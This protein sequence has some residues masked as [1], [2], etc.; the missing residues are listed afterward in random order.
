MTSQ[1]WKGAE[2]LLVADG[3]DPAE[4][5]AAVAAERRARTTVIRRDAEATPYLETSTTGRPRFVARRLAEH[6]ERQTPFATGGAQLYVYWDGAYRPGGEKDA[7]ARVAEALKDDWTP[8]AAESVVTYLSDTSP[9]LWEAPPLDIVN[10]ENGLLRLR[11]R[12]LDPHSPDFLSP[13]QIAATYDPDATCPAIDRF[14]ADVLPDGTLPLVLELIGLLAVPDQRH[15]KA[16]MLLG[17]GGSGKS[18]LLGLVRAFVGAENVSAVA[19]HQLEDDRFA[20]ADLYGRLANVFADLDSRALKSSSIFKS[21]TGGDAIRGERKHRSAFTFRPYARLVFSANEAPPT[22]DSSSAFFARWI[23]I[24]LEQR[25]R[26]SKR[27]DVDLLA[28]ITT[29]AELSGLLNRALD[30]L[31]R[32]RRDGFTR[33]EATEKAAER[34]AVDADSVAGFLNEECELALDG[35][36][37]KPA[38]YKA[39]ESWCERSGRRP[40][41]AVRFTHRLRELHGSSVDEVASQG[42]DY[43]LGVTFRE[44]RS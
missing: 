40:L 10:V 36:T 13:V 35:R 39:Y 30:G 6:L 33:A 43:W 4:A 28:K 26:G 42:R 15:Q 29:P 37:A 41:A 25:I 19:L 23:V 16:V 31:E 8:R 11:D 5:A 18:T 3:L 17:P 22:S 24:P 12:R 44:E 38:L 2:R 7:R 14:L 34:F 1:T 20:T 21:I 9:E 32:L 27:Q